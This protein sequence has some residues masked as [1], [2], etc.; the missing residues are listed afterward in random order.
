MTTSSHSHTVRSRTN[1]NIVY[2]LAIYSRANGNFGDFLSNE[3]V[4]T[5]SL[6][7][8]REQMEI[9]SKMLTVETKTEF[10]L[11]ANVHVLY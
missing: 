7:F 8:I 3:T 1:G 6:Q 2:F 4:F 11:F 10:I 5:L 9:W